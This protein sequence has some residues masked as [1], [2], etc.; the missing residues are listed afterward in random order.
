M[1]NQPYLPRGG[2]D[3]AALAAAK[4]AAAQAAVSRASAPAGVIVEVTEE[5]FETVVLQQSMTVPVVV[6]LWATWCEPCKQL[7]PVLEK[8][9]A[10]AGGRLVLAT[11]DVDAQPRIA[12]A[13]RVQSIPTVVAVVGGQPLPLFQG[14]VPESQVKAYLGELLK[15]AAEA[16][17]AGTI[18]ESNAPVDE[19]EGEAVEEDFGDPRLDDAAEAIDRGDWATAIASYEAILVDV[20]GDEWASAGL[21]QVKLM[22]RTD[23]CDLAAAVEAAQA[24]PAD[25]PSVTLAADALV[26]SGN[27]GAAF[28][29]LVEA[30]RV[31]SGPERVA[32]RQHLL[33]LFDV[34]G[35]DDPAVAPARLALANALF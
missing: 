24:N 31:T 3:L 22:Q 25:V 26:L 19:V 8:L 14:A 30:V 10:E 4:E 16:G 27:P 7:S 6:D 1:T 5:N 20:P 11:V 13:F 9:V 35:A 2:V 34:V 18:G 21:A 28:A 29:L 15:A 32:A 23:G 17:V 12:A 33:D